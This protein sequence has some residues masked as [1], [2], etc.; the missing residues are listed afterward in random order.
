MVTSLGNPDLIDGLVRREGPGVDPPASMV[1]LV[2]LVVQSARVV[3][4]VDH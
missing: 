1:V 4:V 3:I 2:A